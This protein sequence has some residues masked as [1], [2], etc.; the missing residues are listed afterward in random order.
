MEERSVKTICTRRKTFSCVSGKLASLLQVAT[1]PLI[2][3]R[4]A[5]VWLHGTKF[6]VSP[7]YAQQPAEVTFAADGSFIIALPSG[8]PIFRS[9]ISA[10]TSA[11][12]AG[13]NALKH[14]LLLRRLTM[15][16]NPQ[17]IDFL[18]KSTTVWN[19][20]HDQIYF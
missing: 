18:N 6:R 14:R 5:V 1:Y 8:L 10:E 13:M 17:Q 7:R 4:S 16:V 2:I 11:V 19:L 20:N 12:T 9:G 15:I 3:P